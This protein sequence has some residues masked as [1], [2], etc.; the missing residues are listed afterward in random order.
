ME[1]QTDM[2]ISTRS[3]TGRRVAFFLFNF[4]IALLLQSLAKSASSLTTAFLFSSL[5]AKALVR[6]M[7]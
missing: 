1:E 7:I 5:T 4:G 6:E 3:K 2:N